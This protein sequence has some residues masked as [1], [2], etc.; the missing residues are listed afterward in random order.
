MKKLILAAAVL[1]LASIA[2][3]SPI[4]CGFVNYTPNGNAGP[5]SITC[6]AGLATAPGGQFINSLTVIINSDWT[7]YVSGAPTAALTYTNT[8]GFTNPGTQNV[9]ANLGNNPPNSN[10]LSYSN[11]IFGN[12]GSSNSA[13]NVVGTSSVSGGVVVSSSTTVFL[14]YTTAPIDTGV[15]EP[16]TLGLMGA[17][18]LGLGV[19]ARAKKK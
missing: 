19:L 9:T 18:L 15:P 10:P 16:A 4:L 1:G 6:N 8:G 11:T 13:F 12:F 5:L 3:A 14:D 7:G 17:S 2:S